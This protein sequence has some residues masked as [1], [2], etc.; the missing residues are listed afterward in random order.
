MGE[1]RHQRSLD[2]GPV[3]GGGKNPGQLVDPGVYGWRVAVK[4]GYAAFK[5]SGGIF[6]RARYSICG[7]MVNLGDSR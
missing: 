5:R 2:Q 7:I 4:A 1:S 3:S 6:F